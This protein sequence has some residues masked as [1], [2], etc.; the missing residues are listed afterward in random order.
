M[1]HPPH[2]TQPA[3]AVCL[4]DQTGIHLTASRSHLLMLFTDFRLGNKNF[5]GPSEAEISF[6]EMSLTRNIFP[7]QLYGQRTKNLIILTFLNTIL[8]LFVKKTLDMLKYFLQ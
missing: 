4:Y 3:A 5:E 2:F 1:S 6:N 7:K 8:P